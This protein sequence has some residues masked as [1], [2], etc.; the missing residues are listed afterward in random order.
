MEVFKCFHYTGNEETSGRIIKKAPVQENNM[1]KTSLWFCSI[2]SRE[3]GGREARAGRAR[4]A[5]DVGV[6]WAR[7]RSTKGVS[8]VGVRW[9]RGGRTKGA[10]D[11]GER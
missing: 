5:C 10:C 1:G 3:W 7:G 2:P 9:A 6:R 8:D 4:G 11:V